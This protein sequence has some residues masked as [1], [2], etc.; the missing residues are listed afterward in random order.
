MT[1]ELEATKDIIADV[2]LRCRS[3]T[4]VVGFAAE[5]E[6]L[7]RS[8]REKLTRKG[9]DAIVANDVSDHRTGFDAER[10]AGLFITKDATIGIPESSKRVMADTILAEIAVLRERSK[11]ASIQA[12][13]EAVNAIY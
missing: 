12:P 9:V 1:L 11:A 3:G 4:T 6:D 8:A 10:N 2:V 13:G 5:T 7:E